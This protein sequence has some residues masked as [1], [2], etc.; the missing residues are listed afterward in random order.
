MALVCRV[1]NVWAYLQALIEF[2]STACGPVVIPAKLVS[3]PS[4]C[5]QVPEHDRRGRLG[6]G[7]ARAGCAAPRIGARGAEGPEAAADVRRAEGGPS[8]A[9]ADACRMLL[10]V[11][12]ARLSE[13]RGLGMAAAYGA[14]QAQPWQL[15]AYRRT[16]LGTPTAS[17]SALL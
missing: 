4:R 12:K 9:A 2:C 16:W 17:R 8:L 6:A 3:P 13:A 1:V 7:A 11:Q 5:L 10:D 15:Q 14:R